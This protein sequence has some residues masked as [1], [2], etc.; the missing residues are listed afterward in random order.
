M[1]INGYMER[2]CYFSQDFTTID[3]SIGR[4]NSDPHLFS[5]FESSF[6]SYFMTATRYR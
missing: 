2:M 6:N 5:D 1:D 3:F 4:D